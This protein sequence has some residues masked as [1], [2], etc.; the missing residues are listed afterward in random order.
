MRYLLMRGVAKRTVV[1]VLISPIAELTGY[2][3]TAGRKLPSP[4]LQTR[5]KPVDCLG[6][7]SPIHCIKGSDWSVMMR[8][9]VAFDPG[10]E[11]GVIAGLFKKGGLLEARQVND[12]RFIEE[13]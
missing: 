10:H 5:R 9:P 13:L 11:Q 2:T 6:A 1:M 8:C 4:A 3:N 7:R 12:P